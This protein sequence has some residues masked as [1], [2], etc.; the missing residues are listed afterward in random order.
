MAAFLVLQQLKELVGEYRQALIING[1]LLTQ[2]GKIIYCRK[3]K[4]SIIFVSK[5]RNGEEIQYQT[6]EIDLLIQEKVAANTYSVHNASDS[7]VKISICKATNVIII[8]TYAYIELLKL[9]ITPEN[10]ISGE[11]NSELMKLLRNTSINYYEIYCKILRHKLARMPIYIKAHLVQDL[12]LPIVLSTNAIPSPF[13][14]ALFRDYA[15]ILLERTKLLEVK[16]TKSMGFN[17]RVIAGCTLSDILSIP[18][19]Q[20]S[21]N[22]VM[23]ALMHVLCQLFQRDDTTQVFSERYSRE[24]SI[25]FPSDDSKKTKQLQNRQEQFIQI[26]SSNIFK[27]E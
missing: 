10:N 17:I 15:H 9:A 26:A 4:H 18:V 7:N 20:Y 27:F 12:Y 1:E 25:I 23:L 16:S 13:E 19:Q 21:P 24:F 6:S 2:N 14:F 8:N 3:N 22:V 11:L 5:E